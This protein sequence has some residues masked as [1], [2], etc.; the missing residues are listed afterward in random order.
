MAW[1]QRVK[2]IAREIETKPINVKGLNNRLDEIRKLTLMEPKQ[3]SPKLKF[4]LS[5]YGIALV[6]LPHLKGSFLHGATFLD[7]NKIV[8][9]LTARGSDADKFWFSLFQS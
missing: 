4:L 9:G 1:A 7:G 6:F 3:F 5:E 8:L 2:V